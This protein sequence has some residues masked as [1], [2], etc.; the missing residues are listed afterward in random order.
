[1]KKEELLSNLKAV[2]A[3]ASDTTISVSTMIRLIEQLEVEESVP[4]LITEDDI[5]IITNNICDQICRGTQ[6]ILDTETAEFTLD[7]NCI[8]LVGCDFDYHPL[9][10]VIHTQ[11]QYVIKE[12][13]ENHKLE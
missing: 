12:R 9:L 4:H 3:F 10:N 2:E 7:G 1:M 6:H 13:I 8:V 11:I 5:E